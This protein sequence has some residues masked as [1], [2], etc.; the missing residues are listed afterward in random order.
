MYEFKHAELIDIIVHIYPDDE[1]ETGVPSVDYFV[2]AMLQKWTL[3]KIMIWDK[4]KK[5]KEYKDGVYHRAKKPNQTNA[6]LRIMDI[7]W[8]IY[9]IFVPWEALADKFALQ[10]N[11]LLHCETI[12]VFG[13]ACLALFIDHQNEP[14]HIVSVGVVCLCETFLRY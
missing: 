5:E 2:I 4:C 1:V 13:K 9:L 7:D 14:N 10:C 11:P 12:I 3:Q 8:E 6:G